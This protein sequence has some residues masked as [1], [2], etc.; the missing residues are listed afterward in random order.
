MAIAHESKAVI[1]SEYTKA[2]YGDY[3]TL[4][5]SVSYIH[6]ANYLRV[7]SVVGA[8]FSSAVSELDWPGSV[9]RKEKSKGELPRTRFALNPRFEQFIRVTGKGLPDSL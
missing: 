5:L 8:I 2:N 6:I 3:V 7:N 4:P 1:H 9:W